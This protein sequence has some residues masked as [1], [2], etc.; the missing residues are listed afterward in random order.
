ML[1]KSKPTQTAKEGDHP[2]VECTTFAD[3]IKY[4]GGGFQSPWHFVDQPY[5]DQGGSP[6]DYPFKEPTADNSKAVK[7]IVA[8][9]NHSN[10]YETSPYYQQISKYNMAGGNPA[11]ALSIAMRFLIHYVGDAHQ[12][13]HGVSRVDAQY[14]NGDKGGNDFPLPNH[15]GAPELH[16]VWDKVIYEFH[17]NPALPFTQESWNTWGGYANDLVARHPLSSLANTQDLDPDT[18]HAEAFKIASTVAYKGIKENE[19]LP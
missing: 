10:G 15:Y 6:S 16:A 2:L 12:P 7:A 19:A 3:D 9:F 5:Y 14:P 18:W 17:T 13:L 11:D 4:A 8:W 1:K